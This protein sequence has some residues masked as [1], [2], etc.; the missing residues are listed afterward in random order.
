MLGG[1]AGRNHTIQPSPNDHK[2]TPAG[3]VA[4]MEIRFTKWGGR[5]HWHYP[6]E[7]LGTD[8]YG[9]WLGSQAGDF[10][11]RGREEPV[12]R[13]HDNV[14]LVPAHGC[15]IATWIGGDSDVALYIDVTTE[16][17]VREGVVSAVDLDLDV[18]RLRD[19]TVQVLDEDEFAVHQVR[20]GYPAEIIAQAR[21]TTDELVAQVSAGV[22]PFAT[23]GAARLAA[24]TRN[25]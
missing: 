17:S 20:Y 21:A 1:A 7:P 15:W 25:G 24:F 22:E 4:A 14:L 18:V 2:P 19:G 16:P 11:R 12:V 8:Q 10:I 5:L 13:P 23:Q 9:L 6:A 3:S